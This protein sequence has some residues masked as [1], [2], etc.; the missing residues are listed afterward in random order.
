MEQPRQPYPT[1]KLAGVGATV[2]LGF[3]FLYLLFVAGQTGG[4]TDINAIECAVIAR[5]IARTGHYATDI[6]KPL[7]LARF[8]VLENHPDTI[9][10]PLH[11]LWEALWLRLLGFSE[12]AIP[13]ACGFWLLAGAG[14]ILWLGTWWFDLRVGA[15][16]AIFYALSASMMD[17]TA[18]GTETALLGFELLLLLAAAVAYFGAEQKS[19]LR[20]AALGG[21]VGLLYLTS[22]PWG[23]G[24]VAVVMAIGA[25]PPQEY[26]WRRLAA[27]LGAFLIVVSPWLVR[28]T[29][30]AGSPFFTLSTAEALMHTRSYP[31][32]TLYRTFT[33]SYP[34]WVLFALTSPREAIAKVRMG[35]ES[36][37]AVPLTGP[38]PYVGALFI[39]SL[40]VPLG[41]RAFELGRFVLY[42]AGVA[43]GLFSIVVSP[44]AGALYGFAAPAT[45]MAAALLV[46]SLDEVASRLQGDK[47]RRVMVL[48]LLLFGAVHCMPTFVRLA[49][50]R[51][52][53]AVRADAARSASRE[54]VTLVDGLV[55]TDLPWP[56]AWHGDVKTLWLPVSRRELVKIEDVIGPVKW[57]L[58]TPIVQV[59]Q[60]EEKSEEW[61][62]MWAAGRQQDLFSRGYATFRRLPGEWVLFR[63][64]TIELDR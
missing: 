62:R 56:L 53:A 34:S 2:A 5:N 36:L 18:G 63:R 7:S 37:Y 9:Y 15:A 57:L 48:G 11:P 51:P 14:L 41:T 49:S 47:G 24:L 4:L 60:Q 26:R 50:G 20:A 45:L 17:R 35:L 61:A 42:G 28:N 46:R 32:N 30:V 29:L 6:L 21:A 43:A 13:L 8:P 22:Y 25:T 19:A 40:L 12:R 38:G 44:E 59:R 55:T 27:C 52:P 39:A 33:T 64:T 58:L 3:V 31:G 16:G 1:A 10:P 23:L 54:V